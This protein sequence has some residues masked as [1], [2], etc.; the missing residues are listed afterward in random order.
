[1]NGATWAS[2]A[3]N[4]LFS[5]AIWA[6]ITPIVFWLARR[7]PL[8]RDTLVTRGPFYA[9]FSAGAVIA[10]NWAWARVIQPNETMFAPQYVMSFVVGFLIM[11]M[12]MVYAYSRPFSMERLKAWW[13]G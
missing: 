12:L 7:F 2:L 10:H 11:C 9:L 8:R 4:D 3:I 6:V 5:A 1:M 13:A